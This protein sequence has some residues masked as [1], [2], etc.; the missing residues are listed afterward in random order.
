MKY[1][2]LLGISVVGHESGMLHAYSIAQEASEA[3]PTRV[4]RI[5]DT[6]TD[7]IV[8]TFRDGKEIEGE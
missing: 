2:I 8:Y 1:A 6:Y 3:C 5:V 7:R 4:V